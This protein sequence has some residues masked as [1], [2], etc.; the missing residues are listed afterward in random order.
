LDYFCMTDVGVT[1]YT[2]HL[3]LVYLFNPLSAEPGMHRHTAAKLLRW[4][5]RLSTFKYNIEHITS[6]SNVWAD[7]LTRWAA[8]QA[9]VIRLL[10]SG[11]IHESQYVFPRLLYIQKAQDS[12]LA[13][14]RNILPA[15]FAK[16]DK[17]FQ[18]GNIVWIPNNWELI[19]RLLVVAHA[20]RG[21]HRGVQ[22]TRAAFC[23][24]FAWT[25]MNQDVKEF[26]S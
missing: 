15:G 21:G 17:V 18:C 7:L 19:I 20:S 12:A 13:R 2:D 26:V 5:T 8:P 1:I 14:N 11:I 9:A 16:I 22:S 23:E 10:I 24:R 6:E 25:G 3:N 4:G